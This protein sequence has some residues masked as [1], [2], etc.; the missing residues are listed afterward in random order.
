[1]VAAAQQELTSELEHNGTNTDENSRLSLQSAPLIAQ[2][3]AHTSLYDAI[4]NNTLVVITNFTFKI[5]L[6]CFLLL[7]LL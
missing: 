2:R 3:C 4:M 1:M 7:L 5:S 6:H